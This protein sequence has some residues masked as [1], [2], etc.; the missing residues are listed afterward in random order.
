MLPGGRCCIIPGPCEAPGGA[1]VHTSKVRMSIGG[2]VRG[3]VRDKTK[4]GERTD[5][6]RQG[7]ASGR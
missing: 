1:P 3:K 5:N 6:K 7:K 2:R 4:R